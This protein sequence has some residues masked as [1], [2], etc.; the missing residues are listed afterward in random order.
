MLVLILANLFVGCWNPA[1]EKTEQTARGG[2]DE[3]P[4]DPPLGLGQLDD[5]LPATN[6]NA[7][8]F[9]FA[10]TCASCSQYLHTYDYVI[11]FRR[12]DNSVLTFTGD[13]RLLGKINVIDLP[14]TLPKEGLAVFITVV[15]GD[16]GELDQNLTLRICESVNHFAESFEVVRDTKSALNSLKDKWET[17]S[18]Y[19]VGG[20]IFPLRYGYVTTEV[21]T[22]VSKFDVAQTGGSVSYWVSGFGCWSNGSAGGATDYSLAVT[23]NGTVN[24]GT[25]EIHRMQP[26]YPDYI[27]NY[28][29]GRALQMQLVST[30]GSGTITPTIGG[31]VLP[32]MVIPP[33][34]TLQR[35]VFALQNGNCTF[36][37]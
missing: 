12:A 33:S 20:N 24:W 1:K 30:G 4:G 6:A 11:E 36:A 14:K 18:G 7:R 27:D 3:D 19:T 16:H 31:V 34:G 29:Y 17:V 35:T 5:C 9:Q 26:K 13:E 32:D 15:S 21:C 8:K 28:R 2:G 23:K 25:G 10:I 37:Q 22:T